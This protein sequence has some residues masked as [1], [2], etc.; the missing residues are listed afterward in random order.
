MI[1]NSFL[2]RSFT[3]L[4]VIALAFGCK[5]DDGKSS[6]TV[7]NYIQVQNGT[8]VNGALPAESGSSINATITANNRALEGG[9]SP[10]SIMSGSTIT[11]LLIGIKGV[12]NYFL[13]PVSSLEYADGHYTAVILFGSDMPTNEFTIITELINQATNEVGGRTEIEVSTLE[14]SSASKLQISLSWDLLNDIDLHVQEPDGNEIYWSNSG[15]INYDWEKINIDFP[16]GSD[17]LTD[18]QLAKYILDDEYTTG[19]LDLDSDA[20][21]DID[22]VN[23]ENIIY[24]FPSD[25]KTG[26]YIVRADFFSD[27]VGAGTTNYIVTARYNNELIT[28]TSGSNPYYGSF[29]SGTEDYGGLGDGVEVMRF[30]ISEV[31]S[32]GDN[33]QRIILVDPKKNHPNMSKVKLSRD[34]HK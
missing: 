12:S 22:S 15:Y 9:S 3:F 10:I 27:C 4:F 33:T 28:P 30:N 23:N 5:K 18:E 2:L 29:E 21:C 8:I 17:N 31:K 20:G 32:A 16:N 34:N 11:D 19:V 14:Q 6:A 7:K 25:I 24:I 26:E 13:V 1:R